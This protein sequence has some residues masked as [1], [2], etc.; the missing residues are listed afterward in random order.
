MGVHLLTKWTL[1][2]NQLAAGAE[3]PQ[4][5]VEVDPAFISK[6]L[7]NKLHKA[8]IMQFELVYTCGYVRYVPMAA[9]LDLLNSHHLYCM[10]ENSKIRLS[11]QIAKFRRTRGN[12]AHS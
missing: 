1:E 5:L 7:V 10:S 8:L 9:M 4:W 3:P 11:V 12:D 6:C 2:L